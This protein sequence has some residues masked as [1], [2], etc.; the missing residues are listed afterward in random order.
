MDEQWRTWNSMLA[1]NDR[2][3]MPDE[4]LV[5]EALD[6][7]RRAVN[8]APEYRKPTSEQV[9]AAIAVLDAYARLR[10]LSKH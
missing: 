1:G 5:G 9:Q 4:E 10:P 7:L 3:I 6:V 2:L 8:E